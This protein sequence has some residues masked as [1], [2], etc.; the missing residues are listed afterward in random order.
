MAKLIS[1][2]TFNSDVGDLTVFQ[3]YIPGFIK[4]V[5]YI[6][7]VS[8]GVTR[9]GHRHHKTWQG[10]VC[11]KGSC[12]VLVDDSIEQV[13]FDL[14]TSSD[15]LIVEPKDW[16]IMKDFSEDC[17]LLVIANENYD[18]NDYIDKPYREL[19]IV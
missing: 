6:Y 19:V 18:K 10:L 7:N 3:G 13:G 11:I 2:N 15:C 5:Y 14:N 17:I 1:L 9:G 4:R 12:R 8:T 16:H